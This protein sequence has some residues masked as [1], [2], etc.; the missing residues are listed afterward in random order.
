MT[1]IE[2]VSPRN[3]LVVSP[4]LSTGHKLRRSFVWIAGKERA[5]RL[6]L[7]GIW[8]GISPRVSH[9]RLNRHSSDTKSFFSLNI[10]PWRFHF[11][12][13][14][15]QTKSKSADSFQKIME[16]SF[17]LIHE[18]LFHNSDFP[19]WNAL[20]DKPS[21]VFCQLTVRVRFPLH[22]VPSLSAYKQNLVLPPLRRVLQHL[23]G[24]LFTE[25]T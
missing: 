18:N 1:I 7:T 6:R 22:L 20:T 4:G 8:S 2:S 23:Q 17:A 9:L 15:R 3:L 11:L 19:R 16:I 10:K 14:N 24:P 5:T 21:L 25:V 12:K 13:T